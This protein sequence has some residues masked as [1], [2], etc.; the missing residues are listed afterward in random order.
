MARALGPAPVPAATVAGSGA[1]A[2]TARRDSGSRGR[3]GER[4]APP[5]R[6]PAPYLTRAAVGGWRPARAAA[7]PR[8]R[9][10]RRRPPRRWRRRPPPRPGAAAAGVAA[11]ARRGQA[12]AWAGRRCR[13]G[14]GPRRS[15]CARPPRPPARRAARSGRGRAAAPGPCAPASRRRCSPPR[16]TGRRPRPAAARPRAAAGARCRCPG[17]GPSARERTAGRRLS[18]GRRPRRLPL[19]PLPFPSLPQRRPALPGAAPAELAPAPG[20]RLLL[21]R[22]PRLGQFPPPAERTGRLSPAPRGYGPQGAIQNEPLPRHHAPPR[23]PVPLPGVV[24]PLSP[25]PVPHGA[26]A[27]LPGAGQAP[28]R[29]NPTL[30][31]SP[32]PRGWPRARCRGPSPAGCSAAQ[33]GPRRAGAEAVPGPHRR[34]RGS[35]LA[36]QGEKGVATGDRGLQRAGKKNNLLSWSGPQSFSN[37]AK[38]GL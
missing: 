9:R 30:G 35:F 26:P 25:C 4:G 13:G 6:A 12:A 31:E 11:G 14:A 32:A 38:E 10:R 28:T 15:G 29:P 17:R 24:S 16:G 20:T 36:G 7:R 1:L 3:A 19:L 33:R 5:A 8:R 37:V 23:P 34:E 21:S 18:S 22:T 2:Q 27:A